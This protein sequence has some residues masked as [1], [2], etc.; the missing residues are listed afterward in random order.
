MGSF[1]KFLR[2]S[3]EDFLKRFPKRCCERILGGIS[4]GIS[5]K[6]SEGNLGGISKKIRGIICYTKK[7]M[8]NI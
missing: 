4:P 7:S 6:I 8:G 1:G 2:Q 5:G 3:V